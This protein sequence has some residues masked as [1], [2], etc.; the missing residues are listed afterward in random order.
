MKNRAIGIVGGMGPTAGTDLAQKIISNT[1]AKT[2]QEHLAQML[3]TF[4][5]KIGDRTDF[6]IGK[7]KTNPG[8]GIAKILLKMEKAGAVV[9][10]LACNSAHAP[11]IFDHISEVLKKK[12]SKIKLLHMIRE[13]AL[14]IKKHYPDINKVG[15]MGTTG[16]YIV[17]LFGLLEEY[18]FEIINISEEEQQLL[19]SAIYDSD[20]GIKSVSDEISQKSRTIITETC[21]KLKT[22]GAELII[23][24]CTEFPIAYKKQDFE[25][26]PLIDPNLV[27]ARALVNE[28]APEKLTTWHHQ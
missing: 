17:N 3:F 28:V 8:E 20:Y 16:T 13:V 7:T 24:G 23:F 18:G 21:G 27:L 19:H 1:I 12:N 2:D 14:F 22:Y 25:R 5:Q 10:G 11:Q 26:I 6:I 15:I 4:P 9:A